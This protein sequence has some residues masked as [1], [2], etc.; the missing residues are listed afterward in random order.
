MSTHRPRYDGCTVIVTVDAAADLVPVL[1]T[2]VREQFEELADYAGFVSAALYKSSDGTRLVQ[3]LDWAS[4]ADYRAWA[5]DPLWDQ[6]S[7]SRLFADL[8]RAGSVKL[9]VRSFTAV[10]VVEPSEPET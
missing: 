7:S 1:E 5:D 3:Y 2:H 9:D 10:R 6:L 4:A 8:V